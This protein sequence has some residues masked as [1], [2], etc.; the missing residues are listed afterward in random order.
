MAPVDVTDDVLAA[1]EALTGVAYTPAERALM[2]DNLAPQIEQALLRRAVPFA[3]DVGPAT[4][5]DPRPAGF[6][7]PVSRDLSWSPQVIALPERDED[8]AFAPVAQ[9]AGWIKAKLISS[10]RLTE[11][12]LGRIERF[13]GSLFCFATV[14]AEAARARARELDAMT[15][16]SLWLG[17][18]HGIPYGLKDLFDTA[19]VAT[20]WGAEPY[21]DRVPERDAHIVT[22]LHA[23]GA[24][25]LGKTSVGALAYGDLWYGGR[26][27]NPWNVEEGSSGSSAGS[28]AAAAAGLAGFCIGTETLGSIVSPSTRCGVVGLRPTY[29]RVSRRGAMPLCWSLDKIGPMA[30]SVA[31]C[32]LVLAALNTRDEADPFQIFQPLGAGAFEGR[33]RLGFFPEDFAGDEV[34]ALDHAALEIA[35]GLNVELVELRHGGLPYESLMAILF[36]EAAASFEELTLSGRDDELTW[37]EADAWPNAFRKARFLSAVDHVQAERLRT[38]VMREMDSV[39]RQVDLVIGPSLAG[40]MLTIT[41]FSGHPSLCLPSG[42]FE[43]AS[44]NPVSLVRNDAPPAPD[45]RRARVPHSVCLYG[46]LFDEA[47]LLAFGRQLEEAIAFPPDRPVLEAAPIAP[48]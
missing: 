28:G 42:M 16:S 30:R 5:F 12:Y 41:N 46:R 21:R 15:A 44:R 39:F 43:T 2:R 33:V 29:G 22:A 6:V 11:I 25:M 38:L 1:G 45:A 8:I 26:T 20:G 24:V 32:G 23:A 40:P 34:I 13:N 14:T 17:P 36:A 19:G 10:T 9:Q 37:Q 3:T 7:A 35:K 48:S 27:R 18:L 47:R 31:D 4:R